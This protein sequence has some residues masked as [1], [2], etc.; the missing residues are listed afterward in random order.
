MSMHPYRQWPRFHRQL[1]QFTL[2]MLALLLLVLWFHVFPRWQV[3]RQQSEQIEYDKK[4][5]ENNKYP[6]DALLLEQHLK[7]CEEQLQGANGKDGLVTLSAKTLEMASSTFKND[8]QTA[9]PPDDDSDTKETAEEVFINHS[10]RIDFKDLFD[11][12]N[13]SL[14]E[15]GL[16]ITVQSL[17]LEEESL[18]P[19]YQQILKLWTIRKLI[20]LAADNHLTIESTTEGIA[21]IRAPR[22]VAYTLDAK[23]ETPYLLELPVRIHLAGTMQDFLKFVKSLQGNDIFI[24]M[25]RLIIYSKP[26]QTLP[27]GETKNIDT[28]HFSVV[29]TSFFKI[30]NR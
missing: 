17:G 9:Y 13:T 10:S 8:I 25:K 15:S 26:P 27:P 23:A 5:F 16:S 2:I 29:C 6:L 4:K 11:R 20:T 7:E 12:L 21:D 28:L 18:E 14:N 22:V 3:L 30:P 1:L 19:V 24:P